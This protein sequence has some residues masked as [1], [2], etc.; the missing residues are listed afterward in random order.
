MVDYVKSVTKLLDHVVIKLDYP[1][2]KEIEMLGM[3]IAHGVESLRPEKRQDKEPL[4]KEIFALVQDYAARV[5]VMLNEYKGGREVEHYYHY[6]VDVSYDIS[7]EAPD[8]VI[9]DLMK[10]H[11]ATLL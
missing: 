2:V 1:L 7:W 11:E 10:K 6:F 3:A 4:S 9:I 5:H 8:K